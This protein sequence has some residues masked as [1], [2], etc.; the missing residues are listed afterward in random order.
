[1]TKRVTLSDRVINLQGECLPSGDYF[2]VDK[3][4]VTHFI[5]KI[6]KDL[7]KEIFFSDIHNKVKGK[8]QRTALLD[9]DVVIRIIDKWIGDKL[10]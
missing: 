5:K 2:F 7:H 6:K 1:M 8:L 4:N 10:I 3:E 9:Y